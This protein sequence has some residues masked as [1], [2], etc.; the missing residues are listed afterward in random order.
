MGKVGHKF[1]RWLGT[2]YL[3]KSLEQPKK[4]LRALFGQL[5]G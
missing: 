1:G 4:G 5:S 3:Q 2:I